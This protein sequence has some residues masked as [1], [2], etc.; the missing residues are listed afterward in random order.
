MGNG[1]PGPSAKDYKTAFEMIEDE[2]R[3]CDLKMLR[4]HYARPAH[5]L[6]AGDMAEAMGYRN[7]QS[8]NLHYGRL[9]GLLCRQLNLSCR[10]KVEA[11]CSF[12]EPNTVG[13]SHWLWVMLPEVVQALEA[14]GW[15]SGLNVKNHATRQET[16][17]C[18]GLPE[19]P[20]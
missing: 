10:Q 9:G 6:T 11:L 15:C 20:R 2:L 3:A 8:A 17:S 14:L 13:N 7:Y 16:L 19:V 4:I 1:N 5:T 18:L 12:V